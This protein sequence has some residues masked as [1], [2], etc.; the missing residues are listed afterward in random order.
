VA[1]EE[2]HRR[3]RS[4]WSAINIRLMKELESAGKMTDEK[5]VTWVMNAKTQATRESRFARLLASAAA[6]RR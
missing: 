4:T 2:S 3:P 5:A 6:G 1:G